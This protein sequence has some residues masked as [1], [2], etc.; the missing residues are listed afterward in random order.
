VA[1]LSSNANNGANAGVGEEIPFVAEI[2]KID[3]Y[4]T[5]T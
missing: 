4:Y 5:L 2:K 1:L 3:K